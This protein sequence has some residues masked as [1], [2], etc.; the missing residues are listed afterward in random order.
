MIGEPY[1]FSYYAHNYTELN[2]VV[3]RAMETTIERYIPPEMKFEYGLEQMRQYVGRN[4]EGMFN[5]IV[6]ENGGEVPKLRAGAREQ[7]LKVNRCKAALLAGRRPA[8]SGTIAPPK[9]TASD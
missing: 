2:E 1:V 9:E 7:C 5:A 8:L 4:L 3:H 6:E